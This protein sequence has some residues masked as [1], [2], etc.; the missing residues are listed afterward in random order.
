M[1]NLVESEQLQQ[2]KLTLKPF[3]IA[4]K[5]KIIQALTLF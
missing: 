4:V 2:N 5:K 1:A 3:E